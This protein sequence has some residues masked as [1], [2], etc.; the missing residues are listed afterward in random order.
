MGLPHPDPDGKS[1]NKLAFLCALPQLSRNL[2]EAKFRANAP[3]GVAIATSAYLCPPRSLPTRCRRDAPT[4]RHMH[5]AN[6]CR[7]LVP[8]HP[9][10]RSGLHGVE[11]RSTSSSYR[12]FSHSLFQ[13]PRRQ[14]R[15]LSIPRAEEE[16]TGSKSVFA[17][18]RK[19]V[20]MNPPVTQ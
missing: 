19:L 8:S 16:R 15:R 18:L 6:A 12:P 5:R 4:R 7:R 14:Y 10:A 1:A 20:S 9:D 13:Q 11:R 17:L 2:L 3:N